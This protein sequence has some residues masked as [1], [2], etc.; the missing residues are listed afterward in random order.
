[1]RLR[2][3]GCSLFHRQGER[4]EPH[5]RR[6]PSRDRGLAST[7]GT[8]PIDGASAIP[9]ATAL[10]GC[11]PRH[12][13]RIRRTRSRGRAFMPEGADAFDAPAVCG[14]DDVERSYVHAGSGPVADPE[15]VRGS[16]GV[17]GVPWTGRRLFAALA[18]GTGRPSA[19]P[20]AVP[21]HVVDP[22]LGNA[23]MRPCRRRARRPAHCT[24]TSRSRS[25]PCQTTGSCTS[26]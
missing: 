20:G 26:E 23:S 22:P 24:T 25:L 13:R 16:R 12:V 9:V 21:G 8:R 6:W 7:S 14:P 11:A 3:S 2:R 18:R 4:R 5:R 15:V 19:V 10:P 17:P 1:M